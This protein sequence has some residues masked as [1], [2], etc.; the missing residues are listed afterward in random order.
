MHHA[1]VSVKLENKHTHPPLVVAVP[2]LPH[3]CQKCSWF[4]NASLSTA[5]SSQEEE[6]DPFPNRK[7]HPKKCS[8]DDKNFDNVCEYFVDI[9]ED[10]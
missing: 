2:G 4:S 3:G 5:P 7:C 1:H 9:V 6:Q 8:C 10:Y